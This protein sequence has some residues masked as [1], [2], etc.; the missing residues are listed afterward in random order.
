MPKWQRKEAILKK[1]GVGEGIFIGR[2]RI[3][4]EEEWGSFKCDRSNLHKIIQVKK[5]LTY[6]Q[7]SSRPN[8]KVF[9]EGNKAHRVLMELLEIPSLKKLYSS[10]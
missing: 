7:E 1:E 9:K 8:T 6:L 3:F 10:T 5:L 2:K 4:Q